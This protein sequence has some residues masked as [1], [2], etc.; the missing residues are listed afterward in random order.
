MQIARYKA[1]RDKEKGASVVEFAIVAPIFF[2]LLF[3]VIELCILFWVNITMQYAVREGARYAITGQNNLDPSATDQQRYL[4]VIQKIKDSSIG[5]YD[6]VQPVINVNGNSYNNPQQYNADMF[7]VGGQIVVLKLDC[8]WPL[9][10]PLIQ[11]FFTNSN[12]TFS[13][14]ATMRNEEFK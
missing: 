13:V 1:R 10:S 5:M 2:F 4:A 3:S 14:A 9:I 12:Y 7:G 8:T 11:A 6:K